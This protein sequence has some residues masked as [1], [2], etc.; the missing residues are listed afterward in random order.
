MPY[1]TVWV[2]SHALTA[3]SSRPAN[4]PRD[5]QLCD[6][7]A[8]AHERGVAHH[9]VKPANVLIDASAGGKLLLA[10]FGTAVKPGEAA[11]GFTRS[12]AS[13]ELLAAHAL[14]DYDDLRADRADAFAL[15]ALLYETL[16][17]RRLRDLSGDQTLAEFVADGPGLEAALTLGHMAL[18]WLPSGGDGGAGTAPR[19]GY[20]RELKNLVANFL[21]PNAEERLLPGQLQV[22]SG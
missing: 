7:L 21:R 12:Y 18:P 6:A 4:S 19:V 9:D 15:G 2:A 3:P 10:D 11:V 14:E 1:L 17:C 8:F 22:S 5:E 16:A 13:P 20:T